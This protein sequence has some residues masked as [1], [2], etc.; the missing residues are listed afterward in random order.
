MGGCFQPL[1]QKIFQLVFRN[2]SLPSHLAV[3]KSS[4]YP[5]SSYSFYFITVNPTAYVHQPYMPQNRSDF[6]SW[7]PYL[8][9][10]L[11]ISWTE[12]KGFVRRAPVENLQHPHDLHLSNTPSNRP[13]HCPVSTTKHY[14][15]NDHHFLNAGSNNYVVIERIGISVYN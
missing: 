10:Q 3:L 9:Q 5:K 4:V 11:T 8:P 6:I 15:H 1:L 14:S 2:V 12:P 7:L 13:L